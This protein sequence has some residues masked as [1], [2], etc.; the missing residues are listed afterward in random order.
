M[1]KLF[2][3]YKPFFLFLIKFI[4][5]YVV[6][7]VGYK[8]YLNQFDESKHEVDG[9][10]KMVA[11]QSKSLLMVFG[12]EATAIPNTAESSVYLIYKNKFV[13]RIVEG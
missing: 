12:K 7:T 13:A 10:T 9:F 5:L 4:A 8:L 11:G 1:K 2:L 3:Q 6:L